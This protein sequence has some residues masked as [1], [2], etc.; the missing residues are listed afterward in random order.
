MDEI[1]GR[2]TRE[3]IRIHEAADFAGM[4]RAGRLVAT[5][6][7]DVAAHVFPGVTTGALDDLVRGWI[8]AAG[9]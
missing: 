2:V 1:R 9:G 6:L 5:I 7:D 4:E 3:G 8:E